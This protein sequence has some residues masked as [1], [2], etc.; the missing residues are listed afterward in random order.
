MVAVNKINIGDV[1]VGGGNRLNF[2]VEL[3]GLVRILALLVVL[4]MTQQL[5]LSAVNAF[6]DENVS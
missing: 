4:L 5:R 3:C 2:R 1:V 6:D